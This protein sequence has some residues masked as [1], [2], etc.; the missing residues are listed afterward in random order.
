MGIHT[1]E[2]LV[3]EDH[4]VGIDVHRGARIAAAAYGGQVLISARTR[5]LLQEDGAAATFPSG[6]SARSRSRTC[7]SP[8][9]SF[10]W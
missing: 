10:S 3:A 2:P 4:Y 6:S 8:K 9:A 1:G 5:A 7:L